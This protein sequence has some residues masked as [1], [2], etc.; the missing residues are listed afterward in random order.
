MEKSDPHFGLSAVLA[1]VV[2]PFGA[3]FN[4]LASLWIEHCQWLLDNAAGLALF[5]TNSEANSLSVGEKSQLLEHLTAAGLPLASVMVGSGCCALTDTV[6]LSRRSLALGISKLL[7]LPPF[8][9]KK[10][11]EEGLFRYFSEVIERVGET[12]LRVY[13]YHIPDMAQVGIAAPLIERLLK[14]YPRV[15]AGIKDSSND[16][17]NTKMLIE[18]FQSPEFD[19]FVGSDDFL[20]ATLRAGGA[21]CISA[22]VNVNP[23]AIELLARTFGAKNADWQQ[24]QLSRVR[25]IFK[26][27]PFIAAMKAALAHYRSQDGWQH[28]RPPLSML[29]PAEARALIAQLDAIDF[30]L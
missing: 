9:Y 3:D 16:F 18:Q 8:Y 10:V 5:G 23:A 12:R 22:T 6:E 28:L 19:V 4:P 26:Q 7:I 27:Y 15:I 30:T 25:S 21:G 2:T 17:R 24:Q 1:P 20:L 29:S 13:L 14:R 11:S